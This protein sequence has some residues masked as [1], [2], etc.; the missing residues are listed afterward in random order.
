[1]VISLTHSLTNRS[2]SSVPGAAACPKIVAFRESASKLKLTLCSEM[3]GK[4]FR[5]LPVAALPVKV[6]VSPDETVSRIPRPKPQINCKDPSGKILESMMSRTI[7]SVKKHV[8]SDGFTTAG[9]PAIKLTA[10]FSSMPQ[11][12]KLK[13]LMCTATPSFGTII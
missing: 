13:A 9:T 1:M 8:Y 4:P 6:T 5:I 11:I 2:N 12:G 10:I 7:A 3:M